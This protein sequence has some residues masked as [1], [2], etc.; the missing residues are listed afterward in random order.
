MRAWFRIPTL[1]QSSQGLLE[2][3]QLALIVD[4]HPLGT[5]LMLRVCS[6]ELE[7]KEGS[8][9]KPNLG[10]KDSRLHDSHMAHSDIHEFLCTW[11]SK[12]WPCQYSRARRHRIGPAKSSTVPLGCYY[13]HRPTLRLLYRDCNTVHSEKIHQDDLE[14]FHRWSASAPPFVCI[15]SSGFLTSSNLA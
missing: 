9:Y 6:F 12:P 3:W 2:C 8:F 13:F 14:D 4:L 1:G 11:A 7:V 15:Y 5:L 10:Y